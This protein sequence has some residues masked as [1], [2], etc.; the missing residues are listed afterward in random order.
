[1]PLGDRWAVPSAENR[2]VLQGS[3]ITGSLGR[4]RTAERLG[5]STPQSAPRLETATT[6]ATNG[7]R[8]PIEKARSHLAG[9]T[10]GITLADLEQAR[11]IRISAEIRLLRARQEMPR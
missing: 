3:W 7:H 8:G 9:G 5:L 1:M 10:R 11:Y 2:A 6:N 4:R